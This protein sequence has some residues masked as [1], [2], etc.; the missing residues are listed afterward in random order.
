MAA[1]LSLR[2]LTGT[3]Q[4]QRAGRWRTQRQLFPRHGLAI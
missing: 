3:I 2:R 4:H 1:E